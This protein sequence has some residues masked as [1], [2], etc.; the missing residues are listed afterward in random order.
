M[1][2]NV[3]ITE[4]RCEERTKWL[5]WFHGGKDCMSNPLALLLYF[6][7]GE[8]EAPRVNSPKITELGRGRSKTRIPVAWLDFPTPVWLWEAPGMLTESTN[9]CHSSHSVR[10]TPATDPPRQGEIRSS[11]R[12][13]TGE[14][15][16]RDYS[17]TMT[18]PN[19]IDLGSHLNSP[20]P[21]CQARGRGSKSFNKDS[22]CLGLMCSF[23]ETGLSSM[24]WVLTAA[25]LSYIRWGCKRNWLRQSASRFM[26]L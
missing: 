21:T 5:I 26:G 18:V 8:T 19:L 22:T 1:R 20:S 17:Q 10:W 24:D 25:V 15:A 3:W 2:K 16:S 23:W 7:V 9:V 12:R 14:Q 6:T 4:D 11:S 13:S